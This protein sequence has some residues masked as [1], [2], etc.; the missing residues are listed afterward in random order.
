MI[1]L[2]FNTTGKLLPVGKEYMCFQID[3]KSTQ[4]AKYVESRLMNKVIGCV[5]SI[6]TFEQLFVMLKGML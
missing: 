3:G 5:I 1:L 2:N 4:S 6:D